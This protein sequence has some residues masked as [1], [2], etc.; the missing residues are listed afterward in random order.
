[1]FGC[2]RDTWILRKRSTILR[3]DLMTYGLS[4]IPNVERPGLRFAFFH[5]FFETKY[6]GSFV[7]I[8]CF[9]EILFDYKTSYIM[10]LLCTQFLYIR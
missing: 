6:L 10:L 7:K 4:H 2:Q 3:S 1:M 8:Q 9:E 5:L